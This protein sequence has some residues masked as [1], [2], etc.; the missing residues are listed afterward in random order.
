MIW[1]TSKIAVASLALAAALCPSVSLADIHISDTQVVASGAPPTAASNIDLS[2]IVGTATTTVLLK[3]YVTVGASRVVHFFAP[4]DLQTCS[5]TGAASTN[6]I[7]TSSG[8][9]AYTVELQTDATGKIAWCANSTGL[10]ASVSIIA[11]YNGTTSGSSGTSTATTVNA[12]SDAQMSE[13]LLVFA[14]ALLYAVFFGTVWLLRR[15]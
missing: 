10:T 1:R 3:M 9:A 15:K 7:Q 2:S 4:W 8:V 11:W 5:N 14:F 6:Q 12:L 13:F